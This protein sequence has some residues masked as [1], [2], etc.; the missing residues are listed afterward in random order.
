[1]FFNQYVV[2]DPMANNLGFAVTRGGR[3]TIGN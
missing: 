3:G 2:F 1:V